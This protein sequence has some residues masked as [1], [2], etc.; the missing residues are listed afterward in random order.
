MQSSESPEDIQGYPVALVTDDDLSPMPWPNTWYPVTPIGPETEYPCPCAEGDSGTGNTDNNSVDFSIEFGR[1]PKWP[2]LAPGRLMLNLNMMDT[3]LCWGRAFRYQHISQR[4]LEVVDSAEPQKVSLAV[5]K[6][7]RGFPRY[8]DFSTAPNLGGAASPYGG[9]QQFKDR[10]RYVVVDGTSYLEEVLEDGTGIRFNPISA[11]FDHIITPRGVKVTF[12]ELAEEVQ[13]VHQDGYD[14]PYTGVEAFN[15]VSWYML[16]QIWNKADGLLDLSDVRRIKWYAP[17]DVE[18]RGNNGS[19]TVRKGAVPIKTWHLSWTCPAEGR[20][21]ARR[22]DEENPE[23]IQMMLDTFRIEEPGGFVSEWRAGLYSDDLTL[24][25]GEGDDAVSIVTMCR[26]ALGRENVVCRAPNGQALAAGGYYTDQKEKIKYMYTGVAGTDQAVLCSATKEVYA[27]RPYGEVL[28]SR[29]EGYETPLERTW[30]YEYDG[31]PFSPSYGRRVKEMRPDGS[32]EQMEYDAGG[33]VVRRTEPWYGEIQMVTTYEYAGERFNDRRLARKV[34]NLVNG[35]KAEEIHNI[36]YTYSSSMGIYAETA[37]QTCAGTYDVPNPTRTEWYMEHSSCAYAKGRLKRR[38]NMDGSERRYE[39]ALCSEHGASWKCTETLQ[40]ENGIVSGK[41]ERTIHYYAEN[42]DEVAMD[43]QVH[44]GGGFVSIDFQRITYDESHR[45]IRTDY[46]NGLYSSA[47]WSCAGP[48]WETDVRGLQTRYTYDGAKRLTRIEK[49]AAVPV[50]DWNGREMTVACPDTVTELAYDGAGRTLSVTTSVGDRVTTVSTAYDVL[51]RPVSQ[52]DELGRITSYSYSSDGLTTTET[53]PAGS[54]LVTRLFPSGL[55]AEE[56]GTGREARYYSYEASKSEGIRKIANSDPACRRTIECTV[57]DGMRRFRMLEKTIPSFGYIS[58]RGFTLYTSKGQVQDKIGPDGTNNNYK[59][60]ELGNLIR[61]RKVHSWEDTDLPGDRLFDTSFQILY[62]VPSGVPQEAA[63][64]VFKVDSEIFPRPEGLDWT[65][66]S[67]KLV[68][69][70]K[71]SLASLDSLTLYK[72]AHGRWSWE[73]T[74]NENGNI[75]ILTGREGCAGEEEQVVLNGDVVRTT[76]ADGS[77]TGYSRIYSPAGDTL[78][79]RDARHNDMVIVHD[80]AGREIQRTDQ[81]GEITTTVY[82]SATGL[83]YCVT[84][85]DGKKKWNVYDHRGRLCR[86]YGTAVQPM[87]WEYDEQDRIV[88]LHTY[89]SGDDI[90]DVAP[91]SG[92]DVTRWNYEEASGFLLNKTYA[93]G[94]RISYTYDEWGR[95]LT[96]TQSR[97]VKTIYQYD[98][99]TGKLISITHS[100]GTPSVMITYDERERVSSI[101][102]ASGTR[103]MEYTAFEDVVSETTSG[104]VESML[105]YQRDSRGRPSGYGLSLN[106]TMAQ[107]VAVEYDSLDRLS[108]ASLNGQLFTYGYDA[109]TGWLSNLTYPNGLVRNTVFHDKLP[110][111]VSLTYARGNSATP[112]LKHAYTWDNRRRPAVRED[113]VGSTVLSRRHTYG[114][115][116]RG[117]LTADTMNAGGSFSYAYDN[118]GNRRTAAEQ[119]ISSTYQG[120]NLNQYTSV[121]R[122]G[123]AFIPVYDADGN[124]TGVNTSTGTWSVQY[125]ADN[126][127]VLF[128][129]GN[130][131]VECVYDYLGRRVEKVEYDGNALTRRT[132]F[133]YMGYLMIASMDCTQ[134]TSNSSLLGTWFWDPSESEA[135]RVLA[136]CTHNADKSVSST[137]YAAHDLL[138]SVSALFDASGTRQ[139]KFEYTPYGETL[140]AE[141][142]WASSMPF[143][144]S[145]EYRDEDLGLIY[146]NYRHYNPQD[147]RWISRDLIEEN[148]GMHLYN[149]VRNNPSYFYDILGLDFNSETLYNKGKIRIECE[150]YGDKSGKGNLHIHYDGT[151]YVWHTKKNNFIS[152]EGEILKLRRI[153]KAGNADEIFKKLKKG[154]D[155]VNS[156]GGFSPKYGGGISAGGFLLA[157]T[158]VIGISEATEGMKEYVDAVVNSNPA[159]RD[160]AIQK[161]IENVPSPLLMPTGLKSLIYD[162]LNDSKTQRDIKRYLKKKPVRRTVSVSDVCCCKYKCYV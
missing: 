111:P 32:M 39:Y 35:A 41:S 83:P 86:Q 152:K 54:T 14:L 102:D 104:L 43:Y 55:L 8:Y 3:S 156:T 79:V 7:E 105:T 85:P 87:R 25:K 63:Q 122:S 62:T 81:N 33:N 30:T 148:S 92:S 66:R 2:E 34:V 42:G 112:A 48:L 142:A 69:R 154:F 144:Y 114:Y 107:Q 45:V 11:V 126:R 53:S 1:F 4:R 65:E 141:G 135:T 80:L 5:V 96:R 75:R 99:V 139:A 118:I 146:Y 145:S 21:V 115:N 103:T 50:E 136:M 49:D 40:G 67:Y 13:V 108:T 64:M 71:A 44:V 28:V 76:G 109:A 137:R 46:A 95:I 52:A 143:R 15:P 91:E 61:S 59:Y 119:G 125:N 98:E 159:E 74:Y 72:D 26:P 20:I 150:T 29:T 19:Y 93:D 161:V 23:V 27:L 60:D 84:T 158:V 149:F 155:K 124:Q 97:G 78:T 22:V 36:S 123:T 38:V 132:R 12:A 68:S 82:D 133:A 57:E 120:N 138:K 6:T 58:T 47:E 100:D 94:S 18:G 24:V 113:Y 157:F 127:P 88:A 151:K 51:G 130:K 31:N 101:Q 153:E 116:A 121:T 131:K 9:S 37:A 90:L 89:R 73:K 147:G 162:K 77:V 110:L 129:Q 160:K 134:N 16:K 70:T 117:E 17:A 106:G 10:M 140:T 128:T 56:S